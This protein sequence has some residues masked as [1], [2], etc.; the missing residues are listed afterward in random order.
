MVLKTAQY[1]A[2]DARYDE[3]TERMIIFDFK[4]K[5]TQFRSQTN[6]IKANFQRVSNDFFVYEKKNFNIK[7]F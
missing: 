2:I 4:G 6:R 1:V 3:Q 7:T 5:R